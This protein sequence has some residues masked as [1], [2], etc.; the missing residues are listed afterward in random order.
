MLEKVSKI[1]YQK[2]AFSIFYLIIL[3]VFPCGGSPAQPY[4]YHLSYIFLLSSCI[5]HC[6][7]G[8]ESHLPMF[9][10]CQLP[11]L[12]QMTLHLNYR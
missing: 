8:C 6:V 12:L 11:H 4:L 7:V 5:I 10:S 9:D 2:V 1:R 3:L